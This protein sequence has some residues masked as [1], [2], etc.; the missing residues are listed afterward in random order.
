MNSS[1]HK[2]EFNPRDVGYFLEK[3]S[4]S[5]ARLLRT[6]DKDLIAEII[7]R[8]F[9]LNYIT[10]KASFITDIKK[11]AEGARGG[12][13]EGDEYSLRMTR[14]PNKSRLMRTADT[15]RL[16][17]CTVLRKS[18]KAINL[19][20]RRRIRRGVSFRWQTNQSTLYLCPPEKKKAQRPSSLLIISA[21]KYLLL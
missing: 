19:P 3:I 14:T 20:Q 8:S 16:A 4:F 1:L 9:R 18:G 5:L 17:L 10:L 6:S 15:Y 12:N 11:V 21:T 13:E 2:W 7:P